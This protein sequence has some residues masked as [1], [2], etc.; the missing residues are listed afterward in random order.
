MKKLILLLVFAGCALSSVWAQ[1]TGL[2]FG[3]QVSPTIGWLSDNNRNI[4]GSGSNLGLSLGLMAEYFFQEN[5][6]FTFG[7]GFAF[8]QGGDLQHR[9]PGR[10]WP[11]TDRFPSPD[12]LAANTELKYNIQYVEIPFGLKMR[13]RQY[14]YIRYFLQPNVLIGFKTQTKGKLEGP[15]SG[16][17]IEDL[18]IRREVN[19][20]N[21]G[22]GI[23]GG[24]EFE[25]SEDTHLVGGFNL[26]FGIVDIS[27]D[28][29]D[30]VFDPERPGVALSDDSKTKLNRFTIRIGI[31][32]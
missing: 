21:M 20:L 13:T 9:L 5:Y 32:F 15:N 22:I 12:T 27:K 18:D 3:F 6:A 31:L 23:G 26:L 4:E 1:D 17:E 7:A 19:L 2:K 25:I 10:Y 14:G 29:S 16:G 11:E 28:Q 24:L 30:N 8:N